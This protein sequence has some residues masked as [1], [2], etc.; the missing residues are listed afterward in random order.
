MIG[1]T[2]GNASAYP[3]PPPLSDRFDGSSCFGIR[4]SLL[5]FRGFTSV[6]ATMS[7]V[8]CG[9]RSIV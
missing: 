4:K 5:E 1:V 3:P 7:I 8:T 9:T 6:Q 2:E